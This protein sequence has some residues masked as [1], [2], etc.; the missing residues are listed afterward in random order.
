METGLMAAGAWAKAE[1]GA[2]ELGDKR[3]TK[4]LVRVA[5]GLAECP[6]GTL[7]S[8]FSEGSDLKGAYRLFGNEAVRYDEVMKPH[9]ERTAAGCQAPGAYLL[10]EDT[11]S[12]DFTG[13]P[14]MQGLG[15]IGDDGGLGLHLHSTL[16][17]RIERWSDAQEP[18]VTLVGL[19]GQRVWA[20]P[21][22]VRCSQESKRDRLKRPR[23][24]ERW[25]AAVET[26][27]GPPPGVQWTYVAD[28][29]SDV[30]EAFERCRGRRTD[31]I[32]RASHPRALVKDDRSVF[33]AVAAAPCLGTFTLR[34]RARPRHPARTATLEV[35]STSVE[36]RGPW[37]PTRRLEP[38]ALN[39][40][41]VREVNAPEG[42]TPLHWVLLTSWPCDTFE[43]A[44]RVARTY[45]QRWL[46]EE[47][48]KALK[49]GTHIE[50]SQLTTAEEVKALLGVLALVAV[51][52]LNMKLLAANRPDEA[53]VPET[54]PP[55][56]WAILEI[57][58]GEPA[59]GWTHHSLLVAIARLGGF[60]ARRSDGPPG[61]ITIW[62]GWQRLSLMAQGAA[63]LQR[64]QNCG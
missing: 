15:R 38:M 25:A 20:R 13:H 52:L 6:S 42:V 35:R 7:P 46:V 16:A 28:R 41:E 49:S 44:L 14:A 9:L 27:A 54:L 62:R 26:S 51:R 32:V 64:G 60:L 36:L 40:V 5:T 58:Y 29:D 37:R 34:L 12:L 53:P 24:S 59:D 8:A 43:Q 1:F 4:R 21:E 39:V 19:F 61:W 18:E 11:S 10:I 3:R 33:E 57:K 17:A 2:V 23:E 63:L 48:H 31:F 45:A 30:Y 56:G 50:E 47:Y 22:T 55:E